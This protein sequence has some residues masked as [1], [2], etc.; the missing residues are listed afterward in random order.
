MPAE[1]TPSVKQEL[2]ALEK[3]SFVLKVLRLVLIGVA[4]FVLLWILGV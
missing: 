3:R 4:V 1:A 2:H